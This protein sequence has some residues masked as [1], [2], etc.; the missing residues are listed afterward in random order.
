VQFGND[1]K[2]AEILEP[3]MSV[4]EESGAGV[5]RPSEDTGSDII[6][7]NVSG[8]P[9]FTPIQDARKYFLWHHTPADTLDKVDPQELRENATVMAVLAY[10][11]ANMDGEL[12]RKGKPVPDF[13]K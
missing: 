4:L 1:E 10:A 5:I 7:L 6:P 13:L 2:L 9:T 3:V 12:P 8:V 11:L